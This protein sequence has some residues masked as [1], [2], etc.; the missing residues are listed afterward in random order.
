M[1]R[2]EEA[3]RAKTGYKEFPIDTEF[4]MYGFCVRHLSQMQAGIQYDHAVNEFRN[5]FSIM[6]T[7][8]WTHNDKTSVVLSVPT[9][10]D[11]VLEEF[12][13]SCKG[14]DLQQI[15]DMIPSLTQI[16]LFLDYF[17]IE[18]RS[19]FEPDLNYLETAV[20]TIISDDIFN[21][22]LRSEL[23]EDALNSDVYKIRVFL[24]RFSLF[25]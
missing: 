8:K 7:D 6:N 12:Y 13:E 9:S 25:Q 4:R 10:T 24:S 11:D 3:F 20:C 22:N 2:K 16:K 18:H 14:Y 1:T 17:N 5:M 23:S 19:F 15:L 21:I